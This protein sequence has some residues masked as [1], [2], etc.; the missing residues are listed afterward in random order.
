MKKAKNWRRWGEVVQPIPGI[1][2]FVQ[3]DFVALVFDNIIVVMMQPW[4]ETD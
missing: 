4:T 1:S 3:H 2:I